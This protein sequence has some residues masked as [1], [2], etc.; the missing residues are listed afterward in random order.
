MG[1]GYRS[2]GREYRSW[3]LSRLLWQGLPGP[4]PAPYRGWANCVLWL[5]VCRVACCVS[6]VPFSWQGLQSKVSSSTRKKQEGLMKSSPVVWGSARAL[7]WFCEFSVLPC[8]GCVYSVK[9]DSCSACVGDG[10]W[11]VLF[12][13]LRKSCLHIYGKLVRWFLNVTWRHDMW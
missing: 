9:Q 1:N 3:E 6:E 7:K 11:C 8:T 12:F 5:C 2:L 10:T 4:G 13:A